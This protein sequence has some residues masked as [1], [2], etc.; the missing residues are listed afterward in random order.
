MRGYVG[1]TYRVE[2]GVSLKTVVFDAC[3]TFMNSIGGI[4]FMNRTKS[5]TKIY[6]SFYLFLRRTR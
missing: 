4:L 3:E 2:V 1:L 5:R 6:F